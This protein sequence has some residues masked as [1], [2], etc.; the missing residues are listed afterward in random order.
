MNL[1]GQ[2]ALVTGAS[3]G[4][5]REMARQLAEMGASL[6]VTARR[7][8]RLEELAEE[9]TKKHGVEVAVVASDLSDPSAVAD[10]FER[11]EGAGKTIDI[12]INNAGFGTQLPF[13]EIPWETTQ[14]QL[15][16]NMASLTELCFRFAGPMRERGRGYILNVAS[17]GAYQP[18]PTFATYAAGKAYVRNF[19]EALAFELA[20]T[21]VHVCCL[22]PGGTVTEF[23]DVAGQELSGWVQTFMM[24]AGDCARIGLRALFRG[25]RNIVS[26][27]SNKLTCFLLRFL[28][29]RLIVWAAAKVMEGTA[30]A[31]P[32]KS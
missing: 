17:I 6:V 26:G 9:L 16:L 8:E 14:Q 25:R 18:V 15:Q 32:A 30:P 3:S 5:G 7:K 21:G 11:T 24:S 19:S 1:D 10:L 2:R 22:C 20:D 4:I 13:L 23:S 31:L 29:R 28:P 12:L 27:V